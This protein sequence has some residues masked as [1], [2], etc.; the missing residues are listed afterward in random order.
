MSVVAI[1]QS[2]SDYNKVIDDAVEQMKVIHSK[3]VCAKPE[4][5]REYYDRTREIIKKKTNEI[6]EG[7]HNINECINNLK[8]CKKSIAE[9]EKVID[10]ISKTSNSRRIGT[11]HGLCR[12]T[13]KEN[14][15]SMDEIEK[16]V[17]D[18][19]Y[20]E[21]DEIKKQNGNS[22]GGKNKFSKRKK[23]TAKNGN[24]K[25][26]KRRFIPTKISIRSA[27]ETSTV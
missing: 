2:I 3:Y 25:S 12:Q 15:I 19:P 18:F 14:K 26:K 24:N 7:K 10:K 6:N 27:D 21:Q 17:F 20:D 9:L 4:D 23:Y 5:L 1:E 13:I 11:L 8:K 22:T 16:T